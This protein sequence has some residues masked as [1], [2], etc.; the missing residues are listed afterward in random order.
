MPVR[1]E[2]MRF[3]KETILKM[4]SLVEEAIRDSVKSLLEK[5]VELANKVIKNDRLVN[6]YDVKV[7]EE[8]IKLIAIRQPVGGDLRF[9][10]T[11]MKITTDLE[12]IADHAVNISEKA[13][14]LDIDLIPKITL[15]DIPRMKEI[16]Q[17]MVKNSIDSF[18]REDR[19]LAWDV[20]HRDDEV[21]D[22]NSSLIEEIIKQMMSLPKIIATGTKLT[23]ISKNIERIADHATN[24]A[25]MVI[26]MIDGKMI[27][28]TL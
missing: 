3:L 13:I 18:V 4:A 19:S 23:Y 11:A 25:E 7:E 8:C 5:D 14:E 10:T 12:R 15:I 16:A 24:I 6:M 28:H 26:Y 2:E 9:I 17:T 21:D 20:I 1:D 22:I 27:R